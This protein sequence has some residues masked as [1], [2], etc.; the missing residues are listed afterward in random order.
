MAERTVILVT[1]RHA[2]QGGADRVLTLDQGRLVA[3]ALGELS[4][5]SVA[6]L[7]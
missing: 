5:R 1:H 6:V 3:P 2:W 4:G 7:P